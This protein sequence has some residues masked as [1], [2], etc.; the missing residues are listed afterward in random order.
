RR[1]CGCAQPGPAAFAAALRWKGWKRHGQVSGI[2]A[3]GP[4]VSLRWSEKTRRYFPPWDAFLPEEKRA[5]PRPISQDQRVSCGRRRQERFP[6]AWGLWR[7]Q[8]DGFPGSPGRYL[9]SGIF[10]PVS[11]LSRLLLLREHFLQYIL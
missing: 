2:P 10:P 9:L 6:A 5:R 4:E 8:T 3:P 11:C 1:W 7:L